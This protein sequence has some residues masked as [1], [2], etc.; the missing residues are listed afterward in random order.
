MRG[1]SNRRDMCRAPRCWM[2]GL[3]QHG[4]SSPREIGA[5]AGA[6]CQGPAQ[7]ARDGGEAVGAQ[8][9]GGRDGGQ[10]TKGSDGGVAM[11]KA[12]ADARYGTG[13]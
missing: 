1:A 4:M 11:E 5:G 12:A 9:V 8:V 10:P 13:G 2:D 6:A 7:P 3:Q